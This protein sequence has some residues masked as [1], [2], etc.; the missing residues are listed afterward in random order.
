MNF[1]HSLV[2]NFS[3]QKNVFFYC[4]NI[5]NNLLQV[6]WWWESHSVQHASRLSSTL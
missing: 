5:S 2:V 4:T 3:F 1:V 6:G